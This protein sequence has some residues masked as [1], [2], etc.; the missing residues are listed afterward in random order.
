[1]I[2]RMDLG[3]AEQYT[4]DLKDILDESHTRG[5]NLA[6]RQ[7]YHRHMSKR[8]G[9]RFHDI[10]NLVRKCPTGKDLHSLV[11]R[12]LWNTQFLLIPNSMIPSH[13]INHR[14]EK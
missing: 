9:H 13:L 14:M 10:P 11:V 3:I 8:H 7:A 6:E 5:G 1:M 12:I 4:H 2:Q